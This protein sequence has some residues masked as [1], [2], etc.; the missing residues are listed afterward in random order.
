MASCADGNLFHRDIL[1]KTFISVD[2]RGTRAGAATAVAMNSESISVPELTVTLD[3]PFVFMILD[4]TND[5]DL[6]R[7][8]DRHSGIGTPAGRAAERARPAFRLTAD[9][10]FSIAAPTNPLFPR[11]V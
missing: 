6:Y 2:E 10:I 9:E 3:R 11:F 5:A 4:N 1:H 7:R 8:R